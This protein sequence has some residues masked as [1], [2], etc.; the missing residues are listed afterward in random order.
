MSGGYLSGKW[1]PRA[2]QLQL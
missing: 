1:S 2:M